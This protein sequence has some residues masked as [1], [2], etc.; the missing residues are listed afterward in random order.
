MNDTAVV[1]REEI[2]ALTKRPVIEISVRF[3]RPLLK[4]ECYLSCETTVQQHTED[5]PE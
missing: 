4:V 2:L 3:M 5:K 1:R